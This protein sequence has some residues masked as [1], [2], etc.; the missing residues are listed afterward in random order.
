MEGRADLCEAFL[1]L[2][3]QEKF[4]QPDKV[5]YREERREATGLAG[6]AGMGPLHRCFFYNTAIRAWLDSEMKKREERLKYKNG[7][8]ASYFAGVFD[9]RGGWADSTSG[10]RMPFLSGDRTD[11]IVL[12]RLGFRVKKERGKL[13]ILSEDFYS[14]VV[15]YL[16]LE[17]G[18][19]K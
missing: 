12:L 7:F 9:A 19:K 17:I 2:C 15:P 8:A 13:A 16:R 11:E 4:C 18:K 5:Q 14:W 6:K 10:A 1:Q 3:L